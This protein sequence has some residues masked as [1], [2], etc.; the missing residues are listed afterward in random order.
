LKPKLRIRIPDIYENTD[1][2]RAFAR[3]LHA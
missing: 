2:E 3:L 1:K